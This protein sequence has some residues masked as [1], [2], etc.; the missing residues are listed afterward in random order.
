M[1]AARLH[2]AFYSARAIGLLNGAPLPTLGNALQ[3]STVSSAAGEATLMG[4]SP[5]WIL[6]PPTSMR[7]GERRATEAASDHLQVDLPDAALDVDREGD[8][9]ITVGVVEYESPSPWSPSALILP[10]PPSALT[11]TPTPLGS[12]T[13]ASPTPPS[14]L[15]S[16]SWP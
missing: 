15:A 4:I 5:N 2:T 7:P 6:L 14:M 3:P 16:R 11:L 8:V 9:R 13:V 12:I 10:R 1:I